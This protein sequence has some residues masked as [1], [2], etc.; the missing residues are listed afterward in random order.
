MTTKHPETL[1]V[2]AHTDHISC[3]GGG[4]LGHP[5]VYYT[6]QGQDEIVCGYCD[7]LFTKIP[8]QGAMPYKGA[9]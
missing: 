4:V 9:A 3:S 7:R 2:P 8:Q 5:R 6:F 1:L